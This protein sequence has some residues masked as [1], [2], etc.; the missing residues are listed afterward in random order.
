MKKYFF[1]AS[2]I[3]F[4]A[5]CHAQTQPETEY[6][7]LFNNEDLNDWEIYTRDGSDGTGLFS[8]DS[9]I[10]HVYPDQVHNSEQTFAGLV[11]KSE[12]SNYD[13]TFEYKWGVNKFK[14]RDKFV[15]DAGILF[16]VHGEEDIWPNSVEC[17]IQEGDTG[18]M[19]IIGTR[20]S[21]LVNQTIRNYDPKGKL[22]IRGGDS[23]F[24]RFHR[25]YFWELPAW[26]QIK[27]EVRGANAK[28][29]VNDQLV[30]EAINME[31]WDDSSESWKPLTKGKI[32]F[33]AE[34]AELFYKN[35]HIKE[36]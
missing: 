20:A 23:K 9:G 36:I 16:H 22:E 3:L 2:T 17:Q 29:Y 26:N 32:L 24:S 33:Q 8:I 5:G 11:T 1:T 34:G 21:S 27:I 14:P 6:Q 18:D 30:N 25:G 7:L 13:I 31:Y 19:W 28:F 4:I 10:I 35:I 15:R 12:Y